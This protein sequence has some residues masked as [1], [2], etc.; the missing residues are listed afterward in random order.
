ME[1]TIMDLMTIL[2]LMNA[3]Q[4]P[5]RNKGFGLTEEKAVPG[6][7]FDENGNPIE[8]E[9][10][11]K[12]Y[13]KY[14]GANPYIPITGLGAAFNPAAA[15]YVSEQNNAGFNA[16]RAADINTSLGLRRQ[17]T[18]P[19]ELISAIASNPKAVNTL[20]GGDYTAPS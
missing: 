9:S 4:Q 18:L 11:I 17:G 20:V 16:Q 1:D 6:Y 8:D 19:P 5:E 12:A 13:K 7:Y 2:H 15:N 10:A 14:G 3:G